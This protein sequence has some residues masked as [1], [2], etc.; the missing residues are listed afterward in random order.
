MKPPPIHVFY[1]NYSEIKKSIAKIN[2]VT[3]ETTYK[4]LTNNLLVKPA[5]L[6]QYLKIIDFL[7]AKTIQ[8][9]KYNPSPVKPR[10]GLIK[11]LPNYIDTDE[12]LTDLVNKGITAIKVANLIGLNKEKLICTQL[13]QAKIT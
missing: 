6:D 13:Q 4:F 1:E 8:Y 12:F 2:G 10:K 5:N 3:A 11:Y 9:Y 7:K